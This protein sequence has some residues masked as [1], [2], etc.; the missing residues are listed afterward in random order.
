MAVKSIIK[1]EDV[2]Q[3]RILIAALKGHGFHPIEG[4]D[5]GVSGMGGMAGPT[6]VAIQ[7]PE[8]EAEDAQVLAEAILAD[9]REG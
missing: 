5:I 4:T 7:V 6:G 8:E 9:I 1:V 3:A 2:G